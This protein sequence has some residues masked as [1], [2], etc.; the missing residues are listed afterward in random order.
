M[1]AALADL[2]LDDIE[3]HLPSARDEDAE[4]MKRLAAGYAAEARARGMVLLLPSPKTLRWA[5][6]DRQLR[7]IT[8]RPDEPHDVADALARLRADEC[9]QPQ[10]GG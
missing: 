10:A 9:N 8:S 7:A 3:P 2:T 6:W 1:R 4:R 5:E